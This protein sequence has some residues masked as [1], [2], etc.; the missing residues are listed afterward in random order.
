MVEELGAEA[1]IRTHKEAQNL[2]QSVMPYP[3][4]E[5]VHI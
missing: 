4:L 3:T 2:P 5:E 1:A